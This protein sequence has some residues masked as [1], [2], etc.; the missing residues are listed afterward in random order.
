MTQWSLR[1]N[2]GFLLS[3]LA[4]SSMRDTPSARPDFLLRSQRMTRA[5]RTRAPQ[6]AFPRL[7]R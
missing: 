7:N 1:G 6:R 2:A 3:G 4:H 5:C